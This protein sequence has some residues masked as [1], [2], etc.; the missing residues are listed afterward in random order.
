VHKGDS[1][2]DDDDD[3]NNNNIRFV[4]I[5]QTG[6][7]TMEILLPSEKFTLGKRAGFKPTEGNLHF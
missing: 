5:K 3:D 7:T 1:D 2:D 6:R 4:K